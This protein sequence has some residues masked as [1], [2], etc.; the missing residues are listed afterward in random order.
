M[1]L[2][3]PQPIRIYGRRVGSFSIRLNATVTDQFGSTVKTNSSLLN[4][5]L[6]SSINGTISVKISSYNVESG[7]LVLYVPSVFY[8]SYVNATFNTSY[9]EITLR[10]PISSLTTSITFAPE[11][12]GII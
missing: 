5:S 1:Q 7:Q 9:F 12:L 8:D 6:I 3:S 4:I 11:Y 2:L 10:S